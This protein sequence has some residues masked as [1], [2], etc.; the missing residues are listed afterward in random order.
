MS[1]ALKNKIEALEKVLANKK[2]ANTKKH[3]RIGVFK[4]SSTP[5]LI[6]VVDIE[7]KPL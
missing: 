1:S 5:E 4:S 6:G 3:F 7:G 2:Q